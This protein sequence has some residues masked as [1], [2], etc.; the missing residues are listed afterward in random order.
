MSVTLL[1]AADYRRMPW[2]NGGGETVEIA[3]FPPDAGL[4]DFDW[5]ISMAKVAGDG[6][7]SI[8]PEIDR[9]LCVLEGNGIA[10]AL[11]GQAPVRLDIGSEPLLFPADVAAEARLIDGP[12]TDLNVMTRRGGL[13]HA[14]RRVHVEHG[15]TIRVTGTPALILCHRGTLHVEGGGKT[16]QLGPL[17]SLLIEDARDE[18]LQISGTGVV[19]VVSVFSV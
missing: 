8:F 14:V 9:T 1:R 3:V 12:I 11:D 15:T 7:F 4:S 18:S 5:R 13:T 2:K 17:D 19:F 16:L 10:L 6:P